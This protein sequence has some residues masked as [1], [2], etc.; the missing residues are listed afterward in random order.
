MTFIELYNRIVFEIWGNS[1]PPSGTATQLMGTG[2]II[3]NVIRLIQQNK[4]YW[5]MEASDTISIIDGT[6]SYSLPSDFKQIIRCGLRY[7]K[8]DNNYTAPMRMLGEG[9]ARED[10]LESTQETEYPEAYSIFGGE[11]KVYPKPSQNSTLDIFYYKFLTAL[12]ADA[13]HNDLTDY[14]YDA[15]IGLSCARML[16]IL[17]EFNEAANQEHIGNVALDILDQH[18]AG[19][20][21]YEITEVDYGDI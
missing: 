2:G 7:T 11:L 3:N 20:R 13:D 5:F 9:Q 16:K 15:I 17:K 18:D 21:R 14:G 8:T 10:Y 12:S 4:N 6:Q 19:L 1:T